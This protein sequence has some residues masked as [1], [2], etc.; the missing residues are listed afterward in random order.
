MFSERSTVFGYG[1][2]TWFL[3]VL[4]HSVLSSMTTYQWP[5]R[6]HQTIQRWLFQTITTYSYR[7]LTKVPV[8]EEDESLCVCMELEATCHQWSLTEICRDAV[9]CSPAF[10]ACDQ[11]FHSKSI[12]NRVVDRHFWSMCQVLVL[13]ANHMLI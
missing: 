13:S 10:K 11:K 3:Y 5:V 2:L 12:I 6:K 4:S 7:G 9:T 1:C 8:K